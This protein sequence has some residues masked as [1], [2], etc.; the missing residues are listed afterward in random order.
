MENIANMI[1]KSQNPGDEYIGLLLYLSSQAPK[2]IV[3]I[4]NYNNLNENLSKEDEEKVK[5]ELK[6]PKYDSLRTEI[7]ESF[8][9]N[10]KN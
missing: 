8:L 1:L 5:N 4:I 3:T 9:F 7:N 6:D 2:Q 10:V